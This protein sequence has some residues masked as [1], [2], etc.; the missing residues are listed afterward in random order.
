MKLNRL[1]WWVLPLLGLSTVTCTR[2]YVEDLR[3]VC[4][5]RDVLPIFQSNCTQSGCHNSQDREEG[6]DLSSY[7]QIVSKGIVPGNYK[8]SKIYKVLVAPGG[9]GLMPQS[10]Y[11]RLTDAQ[12]TLVA[13]W[14]NEGAENTN[15][16]DSSSCI[17]TDVKF[18]AN[19]TPILQTYCNGCHGG[20]S[21]QGNINYNTYAG[22]KATVTNGKLLGSI[23]HAAGYIAMPQNANKLSACKISTIQAWI[24]AGAPNN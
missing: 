1:W 22:V 11:S 8:S 19:I 20:S 14:I 13:L 17:T 24:D 10:P 21:P 3:G 23:Q 18:S 2:E 7:E 15:C 5:Q 12:I 4:F 6:Y 9:E 16:S